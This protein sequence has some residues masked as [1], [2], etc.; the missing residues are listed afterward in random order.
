VTWTVWSAIGSWV[1]L[2]LTI[3]LLGGLIW[4]D[5]VQRRTNLAD[6]TALAEHDQRITEME[7]RLRITEDLIYGKG[8]VLSREQATRPQP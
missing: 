1:N 5:R 8:G 6:M 4:R 7:R 2:A 3:A